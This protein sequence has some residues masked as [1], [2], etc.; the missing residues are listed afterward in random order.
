VPRRGKKTREVDDL[1]KR[2]TVAARAERLRDQIIADK[3]GIKQLSALEVEQIESVTMMST[4]LRSLQ[5][6]WLKREA[7]SETERAVVPLMVSVANTF[8]RLVEAVGARRTP[9]DITPDITE[10]GSKR[11]EGD[12]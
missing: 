4:I 5:L 3:G 11:S 1:D 10:L 2:T 9:R 7:P 6:R 8:N 12:S